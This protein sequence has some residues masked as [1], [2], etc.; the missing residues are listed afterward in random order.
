MQNKQREVYEVEDFLMD[1]SFTNY[2]FR[3]NRND[4]SNWSQ[5]LEQNPDKEAVV[6]QARELIETLSLSISDSEYAME[7][8]KIKKAI[9]DNTTDPNLYFFKEKAS[10]KTVHRKK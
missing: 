6:K 8:N 7:L 5:W 10:P 4:E 3:L 9:S 1:E 2:H